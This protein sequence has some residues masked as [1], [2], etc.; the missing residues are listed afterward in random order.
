ML[1]APHQ[2]SVGEVLFLLAGSQAK[3][4]KNFFVNSLRIEHCHAASVA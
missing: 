1:K 4:V 2:Q 3:S